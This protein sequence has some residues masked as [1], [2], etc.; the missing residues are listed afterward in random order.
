MGNFPANAAVLPIVCF[1]QICPE[2]FNLVRLNK[3]RQEAIPG[4]VSYDL[5][6]VDFLVI[7]CIIQGDK[8]V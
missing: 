3:G 4:S 2:P 5:I 6:V 8:L 1:G 7:R